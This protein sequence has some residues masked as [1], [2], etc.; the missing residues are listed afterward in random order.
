MVEIN[1]F[2]QVKVLL[3]AVIQVDN[4]KSLLVVLQRSCY[5]G[6]REENCP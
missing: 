3:W 1:I 6:N 5:H 2:L 4:M